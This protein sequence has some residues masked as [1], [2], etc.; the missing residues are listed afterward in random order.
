[1]LFHT[2]M[3]PESQAYYEQVR[4]TIRGELNLEA[5]QKSFQALVQR[6]ETLRS[7]IYHKSASRS[8]LIV[9]RSGIQR[10][11]TRI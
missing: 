7:N 11:I 8:R 6:H 1:M 4:M 9:L 3:E 5:L 2:V 10:F